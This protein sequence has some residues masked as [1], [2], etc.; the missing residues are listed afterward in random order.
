MKNKSLVIAL[1]LIL[2]G[3]ILRLLPHAANVAPIGAIALLAGT[4]L[5]KKVAWLI[6]VVTMLITD[7]ILGWHSLVWWVYGSFA[8]VAFLPLLTQRLITL[9]NIVGLSLLG[10]V[11]FYLIT[12][13]GV[14]LTTGMYA[15]DVSGLIN[16]YVLALPFFRNTIIGD[17]YFSALLFGGWQ[18]SQ[19]I[20]QGRY[21]IMTAIKAGLPLNRA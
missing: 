1:G 9:K 4:L 11:L 13:F 8:L 14:W 12:N 2:V 18:L 6:P 20:N 21:G 15:Q 7:S 3:T 19:D 17:L 5:P 16:C 10:S